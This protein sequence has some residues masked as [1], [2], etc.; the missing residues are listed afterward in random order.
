MIFE[1]TGNKRRSELRQLDEW[2][3]SSSMSK[4]IL[5]Q[6]FLPKPQTRELTQ[7]TF[8]QIHASKNLLNKPLLRLVWMKQKTVEATAS[9]QSEDFL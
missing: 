9:G 3:T 8:A 4:K 6:V 1:M 5:G 7:F 2:H